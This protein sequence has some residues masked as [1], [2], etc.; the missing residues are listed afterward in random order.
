MKQK[1][2]KFLLSV[3]LCVTFGL[4]VPLAA[5]AADASKPE[6]ADY[7][8]KMSRQVIQEITSTDSAMLDVY[9]T[10]FENQK[11][12]AVASGLKALK[13]LTADIGPVVS[14][15]EGEIRET[16][17]G[18]ITS[19]EVTCESG[20]TARATLGINTAD[21]S[22][23]QLTFDKNQ[24]IGEKMQAGAFNLVVGMGTVFIVLI[25]ISFIISQFRHVNAWSA[26]QEKV[27]KEEEAYYAKVE[28]AKKL[29]AVAKNVSKRISA[30]AVRAAQIPEGTVV[31]LIE[32]DKEEPEAAAAAAAPAETG[33]DGQLLAVL[34][35]AVAASEAPDPQLIAV[36]TAAIQEFEGNNAGPDGL[37]VRSIRRVSGRRR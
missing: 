5:L 13:E 4:I 17:D 12:T 26:A 36:I 37:V 21:G 8:L 7:V 22:Y 6:E 33:I 25:F 2:K 15:D 18:Y 19:F 14:V 20:R 31:R 16:E 32:G 35:A 30:D 3:L 29:P 27:K 34:A 10:E 11:Q 24:T 23:S 9:I 28:A 1:M